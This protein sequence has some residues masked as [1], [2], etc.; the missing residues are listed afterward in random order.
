MRILVLSRD[1]ILASRILAEASAIGQAARLVAEPTALPPPEDG[2]LLFVNWADR[3]PGWAAAL[4]AWRKGVPSSANRRLVLYGPHTDI[5]A[6]AEARSAGLGPVLARS[7]LVAD[8]PEMLRAE[9]DVASE[10]H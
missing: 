1:L 9:Q 4:V 8:L 6:H 5:E 10:D 2:D 7:K 3:D